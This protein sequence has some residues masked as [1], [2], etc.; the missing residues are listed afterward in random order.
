MKMSP[1]QKKEARDNLAMLHG[2]PP[3]NHP[4]NICW[5]DGYYANSL[6]AKWGMSLDVLDK[7]VNPR[8]FAKKPQK[9]SKTVWVVTKNDYPA[10]VFGSPG[11]ANAYIREQR[12][13]GQTAKAGI[14]HRIHQLDLEP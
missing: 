4:G 5:N 11:G 10:A 9:K 3:H 13:N 12:A 7:L 8:L 14:Y 2:R 1:K 6:V